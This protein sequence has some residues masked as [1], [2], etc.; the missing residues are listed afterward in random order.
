M[1]TPKKVPFWERVRKQSRAQKISQKELALKTGNKFSTFK[2]WMCY[3][4]YPDVETACD[5][6]DVL[7]VPVQYL[8]RGSKSTEVEDRIKNENTRISAAADIKKL[9]KKIEKKADGLSNIP[10]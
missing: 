3:G 9:V 8:V 5:I 6:A 7:N 4:Y 2:F 1:R 10:K